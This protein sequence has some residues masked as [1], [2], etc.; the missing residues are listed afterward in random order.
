MATIDDATFDLYSV[1]GDLYKDGHKPMDGCML[2]SAWV[3]A[4]LNNSLAGER[5]G[6]IQKPFGTFY[7]ELLGAGGIVKTA[8]FP[9]TNDLMRNHAAWRNL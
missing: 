7:N 2:S 4:L 5:A 1:M 3:P 8:S 6:N 9:A